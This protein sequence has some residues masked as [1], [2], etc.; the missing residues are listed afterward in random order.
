[1]I[2]LELLRETL[3]D[4]NNNENTLQP[5]PIMNKLIDKGYKADFVFK[6]LL[7][8]KK[9]NLFIKPSHEMD[10][11]F[12]VYGLSQKGYEFLK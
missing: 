4:I 7:E 3:I 8:Y 6:Q 12:C 11:G 10:G 5:Y 9:L 2:D 1:M